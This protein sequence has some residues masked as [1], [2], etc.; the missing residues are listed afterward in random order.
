[1]NAISCL[2]VDDE[3]PARHLLAHFIAQMPGLSLAGSCASA[4]EA[5]AALQAGP[6][7]LLFL[8]I[9]MPG[10]T[11]VELLRA[12]PRHPLTIFT[13]AY[14]HYALE[15]YRLD[16]ADYLLKPFGFGR[17]V[18]AVGKASELLRLRR[19]DGQPAAPPR[20]AL[21]V[22]SEH[23][24]LRI[25]FDEIRYVQ[26]MGEY[27]VYYTAGGKVMALYSLKKLEEELPPGQFLRIHKSYIVP[28]AR[29]LSV[30][31]N[32]L[33][34]PGQTLPIGASYKAALLER[35]GG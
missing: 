19:L 17:F 16:V 8:D 34:L 5:L 29:V 13:T 10:L 35:L 20:D 6:V 18:E 15:G 24:L 14:E 7:D 32:M 3:E 31:G 30:E 4:P 33:H 2:V 1:M 23:K 22:K 12:L 25:R 9:Q 27:V 11:G 26:G 21:L 28:L